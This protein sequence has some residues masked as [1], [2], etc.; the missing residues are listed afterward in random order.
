MILDYK[1]MFDSE[2]L[3]KCMNDVFEAGVKDDL[4]NLMFEANKENYVAVKTPSGLSRRELFRE[5]VMQGDV[6][7]PLVSSL[8]MDTMGRECR[9]NE[10]HLYYDKDI[11]PVPPLGMVDDLFSISICGYKQQ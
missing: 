1:Q 8:Q 5:I 11:V 7:A 9:E 2:R 6:L 3:F 10:E 4:F